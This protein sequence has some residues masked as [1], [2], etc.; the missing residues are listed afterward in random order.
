MPYAI[1]LPIGET[2]QAPSPKLYRALYSNLL[3]WMDA[4]YPGLGDVIHDRPVRKPFTI[5]ALTQDRDG[6]WRWRVTLLEDDLF[7]PLWAG[8]QA[9]GEIDLNGRTWPVRWPD[10]RIVRR[11]YE[12]LLTSVQPTESISLKFLSP[13]TFRQGDLDLPL[14]EPMAVFRSWLSQ[15]NEFAPSHRHIDTEILD[16]VYASVAVSAHRLRTEWHDLGYSQIVGFVGEV[17]FDILDARRLNQAVVWQ[18]N[19]LADYAEFCGTGRK[20]THGMGQTRRIGRKG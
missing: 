11:S 17:T 16:V 1:D 20:T 10:A 15:W 14:P 12:F 8:V 3:K 5:S 19:A 13:T 4:A 9:V 7:E 2:G 6:Q 18:L